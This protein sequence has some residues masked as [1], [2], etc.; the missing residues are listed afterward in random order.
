MCKLIGP[1]V[2]QMRLHSNAN[3]TAIYRVLKFVIGKHKIRRNDNKIYK[4]H[5]AAQIAKSLLYTLILNG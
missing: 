2:C 5:A 4:F 3:S 1:T